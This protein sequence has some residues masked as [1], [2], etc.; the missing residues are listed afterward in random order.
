MNKI[1]GTKQ[2]VSILRNIYKLIVKGHKY[3]LRENQLYVC[4]RKK[5]DE[6]DLLPGLEDGEHSNAPLY[7]DK[8]LDV[9]RL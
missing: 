4:W 5:L 7:A 2:P 1:T 8:W 6:I 3:N 9:W